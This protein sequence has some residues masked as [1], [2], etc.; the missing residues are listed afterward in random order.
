MTTLLIKL[1]DIQHYTTIQGS[2]DTKNVN[3][4]INNA[5]ILYIEPILGSDLFEK[6][7]NLISG[8]TIKNNIDYY[9]LWDEYIKPALVFHT[10][11]LF[12]P[13]QSF[14]LADGGTFQYETTNSQTS[15]IEYIEKLT[16]KYKVIGSKYDDKLVKYL[17]DNSQL[18]S[19]YH[20]NQGLIKKTETTP[21]IDWYLGH[22]ESRIR[23]Y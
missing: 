4:H 8:N 12:I 7:Q 3:P 5:Q 15:T 10:M 11:Q 22:Q 1:E 19:E 18:F 16:A 17:C 6:I 13:L 2:V 23:F 20:N 14:V 21:S 9:K